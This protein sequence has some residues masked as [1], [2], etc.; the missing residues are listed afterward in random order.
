MEGV[1]SNPGTFDIEL[2]WDS[3]PPNTFDNLG[4]HLCNCDP[5]VGINE[6]RAD[7]SISIFPNP[8]NVGYFE[9]SAKEFIAE[10]IVYSITGEKVYEK[11]SQES[12]LQM[13]VYTDNWTPG[14]YLVNI[15]TSGNIV[16]TKR[17]VIK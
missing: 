3:L 13:K 6:I 10:V 15:R 9:I 2:E 5:A 17:I 11:Y 7:A 8:S 16:S 1:T 4:I 12:E 14:A